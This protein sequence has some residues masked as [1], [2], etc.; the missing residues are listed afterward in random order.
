[1]SCMHNSQITIA[2]LMAKII[3]IH[4]TMIRWL[5]ETVIRQE[6]LLLGKSLIYMY[7]SIKWDNIPQH[8][9]TRNHSLNMEIEFW[10][11]NIE[12]EIKLNYCSSKCIINRWNFQDAKGSPTNWYIHTFH[13]SVYLYTANIYKIHYNKQHKLENYSSAHI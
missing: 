11:R 8:V 3:P 6:L 5:T 2:C 7:V 9:T 4:L 13:F 10:G 12:M 1:M